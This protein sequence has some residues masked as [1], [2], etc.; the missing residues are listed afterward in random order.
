MSNDETTKLTPP[1]EK[2]FKEWV[3]QNKITDVNEPDSFYDYRGAFK[4]GVSPSDDKHWPDTFKQHGHP[5]FSVES[6]YSKGPNDGGT[7]NDNGQFIPPRRQIMA[8]NTQDQTQYASDSGDVPIAQPQS[9]PGIVRDNPY[10]QAASASPVPPPANKTITIPTQEIV[11]RMPST[12]VN[13]TDY[14]ASQIT[15]LGDRKELLNQQ[16]D[17]EKTSNQRD[18]DINARAAQEQDLILNGDPVKFKKASSDLLAAQQQLKLAPPGSPEA[19]QAQDNLN[20]ARIGMQMNIGSKEAFAKAMMDA[21]QRDEALRAQIRSAAA[22]KPLTASDAWN[23]RS[24]GSKIL[25]SIGIFLGGVG[26][27]LSHTGKNPAMEV[28]NN[29]INSDIAANREH[30]EHNWKAIASQHELD[31]NAFNRD[32]HRQVWENNYRT[33]SLERVKLELASSGAQ[34]KSDIVKVN[35]A[36]GIQDLT[37]EQMKIR[38]NQYVLGQQAAQANAARLRGLAKDFTTDV[39]KYAE[40]EGVSFED[41]QRAVAGLPQYRPLMGAGNAYTPQAL[42]DDQAV[43]RKVMAAQAAV[44]QG[45]SPAEAQKKFGI[46]SDDMDRFN[47][48]IKSVGVIVPSKKDAESN[49]DLDARTVGY[50]DGQRI[51]ASSST[52]ADEYKAKMGAAQQWDANVLKLQELNKKAKEQGGLNTSQVAEWNAAKTDMIAIYGVM[53]EGSKKLPNQAEAERLEKEIIGNPPNASTFSTQ[54]GTTFS[55]SDMASKVDTRMNNLSSIGAEAR[56]AA[57]LHLQSN[58]G[59][60]PQPRNPGTP[61]KEYNLDGTPK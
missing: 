4:A 31:S 38:N 61:V 22:E 11:S 24:T 57:N 20:T 29:A 56:N 58:A 15:S 28:V 17:I 44:K 21:N 39:S 33:A 49:K 19:V 41:A 9:Q 6:Q 55:S 50:K 42:L 14:A 8:A 3:K 2:Q 36:R 23:Q 7:W 52:Q 25:A 16:A 26:G 45:M 34:S 32:M 10:G 37:D 18:A 1:E 35:A 30:M 13:N 48:S 27:G 47:K 43:Q 12:P 54:F 60:T 53:K 51:L 40:K 59:P 46:D 5:T